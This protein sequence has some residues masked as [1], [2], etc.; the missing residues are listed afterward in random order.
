[1]GGV[2]P[3][4]KGGGRSMDAQVNLVPYIDLLMTIMT[5]LVMTAVWTQIASLEV[6]AATGSP[7]TP[8]EPDPDAP[9]NIIVMLTATE[10]KIIEEGVDKTQTF[11]H[12][13]EDLA[14]EDITVALK[15]YKDAR[16][17]RKVVKIKVE[18]SIAFDRIVGV[19]D[20]AR[21]LELT[22]VSLEPASS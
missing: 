8:S 9:K 21:S 13:G 5:F 3:S 4:G 17:D 16:P 18:D 2:Q 22:A 1:M 11:P 6:Q 14:V 15:A 12:R 7:E 10:V 19:I 20:V